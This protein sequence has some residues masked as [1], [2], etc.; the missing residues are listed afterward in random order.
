MA[1]E[2]SSRVHYSPKVSTTVQLKNVC[3]IGQTLCRQAGIGSSNL[4]LVLAFDHWVAALLF[5]LSRPPGFRLEKIVATENRKPSIILGNIALS[6]HRA[7]A[8]VVQ[9]ILEDSGYEVSTREAPH[10]ELFAKQA[11]G[12]IDILASAWLPASH[13]RYIKTYESRVQILTPHYEPYCIW[14]VP[15]YVPQSAVARVS[16]LVRPEVAEK[17]TRQIDG[18]N[19]DAGISRFSVTMLD[20]YG[21]GAAGYTFRSGTEQSF[22]ERVAKGIARNEWFIV[23]IW[24]PQYLNRQ[25]NLRSIEEPKGLLGGIDQASVVLGERAIRVLDHRT[26]ARIE[27]TYLGNEGVEK[28]DRLISVDGISRLEAARRCIEN[29]R[30]LP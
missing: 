2:L 29:N 14:A 1:K 24:R 15:S 9:V 30:P 8:A 5:S 11:S 25:Y 27:N 13:G 18:I 16:D 7:A 3:P 26:I 22:I 12:E 6:F 10:E 4:R 19:P 20:K 21:L 28:I 17:M 23:P